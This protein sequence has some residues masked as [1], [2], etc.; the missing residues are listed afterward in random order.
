[1]SIKQCFANRRI[2]EKFAS[3]KSADISQNVRFDELSQNL[4][5]WSFKHT[6]I[7]FHH[8]IA[9]FTRTPTKYGFKVYFKYQ[10]VFFRLN[11]IPLNNFDPDHIYILHIC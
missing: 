5:K 11:F 2:A 9:M 10:I 4:K 3:G 8:L 1:M 7:E 6:V